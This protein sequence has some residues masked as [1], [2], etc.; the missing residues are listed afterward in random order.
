MKTPDEDESSERP[1][2]ASAPRS[3][4]T[5]GAGRPESRRRWGLFLG[6][7][8]GIVVLDQVSKAIVD[9]TL[10]PAW[11]SSPAAGLAA[12]TPLL[13][14]LVR[15]AKSYNRGGIFGLF[16]DAAPILAVASLAVIALI[17][18]YQ[19]RAGV[20]G[21]WLLTL[22]LGLLLGGAVGNFIDRIRFGYVIDFVDMGLGRTRF[23]TFNVADA[24]ISVSIALLL[25]MSVLGDRLFS[26]R[27]AV[28]R[29]ERGAE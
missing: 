5:R 7:A 4:A 26:A 2:V 9:S 27:G 19:A 3:A 18:F 23:Y 21:P 6:L 13:G 8:G 25:L 24:S 20:L 12:P 10:R 28:P 14:D 17:V 1:V 29:A 16:G 22:A 11:T 15:V